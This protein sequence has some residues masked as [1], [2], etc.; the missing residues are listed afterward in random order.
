MFAFAGL[1][2]DGCLAGVGGD[3][4]A[5]RV[6][7]SAVADFR[8]QGGGADHRV[9]LEEAAED[10]TVRVS[11]QRLA[12]LGFEPVDLLDEHLEGVNEADDDRAAGPGLDLARRPLGADRS[13]SSSCAG[14]LR[15]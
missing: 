15:E 5:V 9:G 1:D 11:V 2:R 7:A 12:D 6:A 10:L 8:E 13:R 4:V 3:R 14:V